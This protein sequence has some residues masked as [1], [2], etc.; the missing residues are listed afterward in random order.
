[1]QICARVTDRATPGVSAGR[2]KSPAGM[3][4][5]AVGRDGFGGEDLLAVGSGRSGCGVC[6]TGVRRPAGLEVCATSRG[7]EIDVDEQAA[8]ITA[9]TT[10]ITEGVDRRAR[11]KPPSERRV[12]NDTDTSPAAGSTTRVLR[13]APPCE[14]VQPLDGTACLPVTHR[15]LSL[16]GGLPRLMLR[17]AIHE[18][19]VSHGT[20]RG[21]G[22]RGGGSGMGRSGVPEL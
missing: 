12:R 15:D 7:G 14:R 17:R 19:E 4:G 10:P 21:L 20:E 11:G 3:L 9:N 5:L 13:R 8:S 1:M 16:R 22:A 6:A 2:G 18:E